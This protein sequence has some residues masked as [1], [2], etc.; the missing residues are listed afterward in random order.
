MSDEFLK[1]VEEADTPL[2]NFAVLIVFFPYI[3]WILIRTFLIRL[4]LYK[5]GK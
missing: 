5:Y 3:I 2:Q 1:A 4:G